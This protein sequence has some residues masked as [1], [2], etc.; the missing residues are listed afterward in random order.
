LYYDGTKL[1]LVALRTPHGV[2][3][4]TNTLSETLTN[5]QM[6]DIAGSLRQAR[7]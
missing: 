3:W 4:V 5:T 6:L 2:Y 7:R 1:K